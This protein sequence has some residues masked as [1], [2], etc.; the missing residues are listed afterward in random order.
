[1]KEAVFECDGS[2]APGPD[3]FSMAVFQSQW[4]TVKSDIMK[5]FEEF[6]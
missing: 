6:F 1:M 5:V 4:A 3:G 2:K